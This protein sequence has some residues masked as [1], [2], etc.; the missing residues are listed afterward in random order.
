MRA[1]GL[2][3]QLRVEGQRRDLPPGLDLTAYRILQ[4]A[5]T[6]ALRHA[7]PNH[8][9]VVVQYGERELRLEVLDDGDTASESP[10]PPARAGRGLIGMRARVTV[11]GGQ[12]DAGRR[13]GRGYAV[14]ARLPLGVAAAPE[15]VAC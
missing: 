14:R 5:L 8:T 9:E 11:Y 1:A 12:L 7:S 2:A 15:G 4:E 10:P 6:N 13:P 3:V